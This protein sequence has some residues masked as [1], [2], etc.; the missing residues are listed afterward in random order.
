MAKSKDDLIYDIQN[1]LVDPTTNKITGDRVKARLLDMVETMAESAGSGG[2]YKYYSIDEGAAA[3][4]FILTMSSLV[5]V[6]SKEDTSAIDIITP[7][8]IIGASDKVT[9]MAVVVDM[10]LRLIFDGL[11]VTIREYIDMMLEMEGIGSLDEIGV[12][13]IAKEQFYDI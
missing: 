12:H 9:I 10:S 3:S 6:A 11:D 2:L 13:E 8:V 4:E 5:K 1:E 7:V